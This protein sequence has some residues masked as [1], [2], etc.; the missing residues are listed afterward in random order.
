[1][2]TS[3]LRVSLVVQYATHE[4]LLFKYGTGKVGLVRYVCDFMSGCVDIKHLML[5]RAFWE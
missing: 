1:M 3:I 4:C 5:V 2:L